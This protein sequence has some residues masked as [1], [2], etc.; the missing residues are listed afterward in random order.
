M[1]VFY[2]I[3]MAIT[4]SMQVWK[5]DS[6][7]QPRITTLQSHV[8]GKPHE[9][10]L[11]LY[12]HMGTHVDA[13]LHMLADGKT[14]DSI[15]LERLCGPALVFDLSHISKVI[16][17]EDLIPLAINAGER[18]LFKTVNSHDERFNPEFVY[19]R[20][21]GAAYLADIGVAMVGTDG[22]GIERAQPG[23]PT[24]LALMLQE[25]IIVEG[26]RL[27]DVPAG[28]YNLFVAP[29]KLIGTDGAPARAFLMKA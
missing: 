6:R 10:E 17:R 12:S 19:L 16:T 23:Y 20:E 3:S 29:L 11:L 24:H 21:D 5:N 27:R 28:C 7:K 13:P 8:E 4:E 22:L 26:L 15:S 9:S 14:I 1:Q 25:V 18:V 2:D